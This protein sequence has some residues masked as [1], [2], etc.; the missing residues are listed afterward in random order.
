MATPEAAGFRAVQRWTP[1]T[2]LE[3]A[4]MDR[5]GRDKLVGT[6]EEVVERLARFAELGVEEL[7]VSAAPLPFAV[8]DDSQLEVLAEAVI[9]TVRDL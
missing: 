7:I 5:W 4:D 2:L 3:G 6:V 9:P 8:Y 1:G